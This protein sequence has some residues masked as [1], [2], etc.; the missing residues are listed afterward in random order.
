[1]TKGYLQKFEYKAPA[2]KT[3]KKATPLYVFGILITIFANLISYQTRLGFAYG[4]FFILGIG[5]IACAVYI[6]ITS[7]KYVLL[8]QFGEDEYAKWRGLYDFLNSE[9]LMKERTVVDLVIWEQYL[10]YATAFGISEK[11]VKALQIR[12]SEANLN[13]SPVLRNPYYRSRG[14]YRSGR[15]FGYATRTAS[16]TYR[17]GSHGG[18]SRFGGSGSGYGG[19]GRGGGGGGGG[20]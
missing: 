12:C 19:G 20:H 16:S 7:K 3:G 2:I 5:F 1:L 9:T 14:F 11:V 8:T 13:S 18:G 15:S 17:S 6:G 10:V 4:A